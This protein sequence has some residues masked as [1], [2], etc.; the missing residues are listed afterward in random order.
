MLRRAVIIDVVVLV[1]WIC[2]LGALITILTGTFLV[3][4]LLLIRCLI[5]IFKLFIFNSNIVLYLEIL[6]FFFRDYL[7]V[8]SFL[9]RL[10]VRNFLTLKILLV[11][12]FFKLIVLSKIFNL[13]IK[14]NNFLLLGMWRGLLLVNLLLNLASWILITWRIKSLVLLQILVN[15]W[16][17]VHL[18]ILLVLLNLLLMIHRL[19][20]LLLD[21]IL[22]LILQIKSFIGNIRSS[23]TAV[24]MCPYFI[25]LLKMTS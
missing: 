23:Y 9:L 18:G 11:S 17:V 15:L 20:C 7:L 2:K 6:I 5:S 21:L 1:W 22:S 16:S 25:W 19:I 4:V 13:L 8:L 14:L 24:I 12:M 10:V 3:L